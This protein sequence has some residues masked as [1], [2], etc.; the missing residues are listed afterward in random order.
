ME[1]ATS[2]TST[3]NTTDDPWTSEH[4]NLTKDEFK[5]TILMGEKKD[6]NCFFFILNTLHFIVNA[7]N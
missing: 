7:S 4:A 3:T 1:Q 5:K 6:I 2:T